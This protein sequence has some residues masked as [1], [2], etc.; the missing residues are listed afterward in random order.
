MKKLIFTTICALALA[1]GSAMA[2]TQPAPEASP[3]VAKHTSK[4]ATHMKH[5]KH[6]KKETTGQ[7]TGMAP[8]KTK[9]PAARY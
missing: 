1:V 8:S 7:T 4:H 5:A 2:Q 6:M 3:G 9:Q